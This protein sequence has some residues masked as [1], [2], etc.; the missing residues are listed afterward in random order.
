MEEGLEKFA[1]P[2]KALLDLISKKRLML[3]TQ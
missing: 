1:K 3:Q 2:Q